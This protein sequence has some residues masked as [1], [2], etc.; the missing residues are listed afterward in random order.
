MPKPSLVSQRWLVVEW[1]TG[2]KCRP[3]SCEVG[4]KRRRGWCIF[5]KILTGQFYLPRS[6]KMSLPFPHNSNLFRFHQV[7][8]LWSYGLCHGWG[9]PCHD[10]CNFMFV[11]LYVCITLRS[12]LFFMW[13]IA[14]ST[15]QFTI[16][17]INYYDLRIINTMSS[18]SLLTVNDN[19]LISLKH[20]KCSTWLKWLAMDL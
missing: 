9:Y 6:I 5:E 8:L 3:R 17:F 7:W 1:E 14:Y 2:N 20:V 4:G 13:H 19:Q 15:T 11:F 18:R 10:D 12:I 16:L